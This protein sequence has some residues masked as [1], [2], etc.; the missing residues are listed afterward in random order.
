MNVGQDQTSEVIKQKR[1]GEKQKLH[2]GPLFTVPVIL[3]SSPIF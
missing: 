2:S 1:G 3:S